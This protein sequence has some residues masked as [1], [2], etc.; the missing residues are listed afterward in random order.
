LCASSVPLGTSSQRGRRASTATRIWRRAIARMWRGDAGLRPWGV[1][2]DHHRLL[3]DAEIFWSLISRDGNAAQD[4]PLY[5]VT[6]S[7]I[8]THRNDG[9]RGPREADGGGRGVVRDKGGLASKEAFPNYVRVRSAA[10]H[11]AE[12]N[13]QS[14]D[15]RLQSTMPPS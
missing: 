11:A 13:K 9:T 12:S 14:T 1:W 8:R 15:D 2:V 10:A 4:P 6:R 3:L 5:A 7:R